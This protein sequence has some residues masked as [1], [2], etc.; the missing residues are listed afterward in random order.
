MRNKSYKCVLS[1]ATIVLRHTVQ[2]CKFSKRKH[3]MTDSM[4]QKLIF[5]L[6]T[7]MTRKV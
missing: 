2:E 7:C 5:K 3:D 1:L 6:N 4:E